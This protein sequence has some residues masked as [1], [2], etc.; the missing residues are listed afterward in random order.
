MNQGGI[1]SGPT[2]LGL[3][4]SGSG[5]ACNPTNKAIVKKVQSYLKANGAPMLKVDGVWQGCTAS[6]FRRVFGRIYVTAD[7]IFKMTNETCKSA[8]TVWGGILPSWSFSSVNVCN[9][10]SDG[11]PAGGNGGGG[12]AP[13]QECPAGQCWNDLARTCVPDPFGLL[14]PQGS[15]STPPSTQQTQCPQGQA[16]NEMLKTCLPSFIPPGGGGGGGGGGAVAPPSECPSGTVK[17]PLDPS[18][19]IGATGITSPTEC[20]AGTSKVMGQCVATGGGGDIFTGITGAITNLLGGGAPSGGQP[21]GQPGATPGATPGVSDLITG[22]TG[23][24]SNIFGVGAGAGGCAPGMVLNPTSGQCVGPG[25]VS[26]PPGWTNPATPGAVPGGETKSPWG[27]MGYVIAGVLG[28]GAAAA[29]GWYVTRDPAV[30]I[31][32]DDDDLEDYLLAEELL[33][34][35]G[36]KES[37][38]GDTSYG[39][40][41]ANRGRRRRRKGKKSRRRAAKGRSRRRSRRSRRR[42]RRWSRR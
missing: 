35:Q 12:T 14:C 37:G 3:V 33:Q 21:G 7:D 15:T 42:S 5:V 9:D 17:N 8:D 4:A 32:D 31:D 2:A 25:G 19:C 38:Y 6:A 16:W 28:I 27:T 36:E 34:Q 13:T 29:I 18:Q 23:A 22:I 20:P 1:F 24:I 10:G 26:V 39:G 41:Y 11:V 40:Y 30:A